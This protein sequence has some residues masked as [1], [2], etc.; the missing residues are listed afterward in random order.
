M[1]DAALR[2]TPL[3]DAHVSLGAKLVPFAG[4]EMPIQYPSG[5]VAE[6]RTVRGAVGLF[7]LSHM[8]EFHFRGDAALA[9][10]DRLVSS[11]IAGL[12]TGQ[13][14]YGLLCNEGGTIVDDVIVYRV[15]DDEVL[16]VVN[17]SNVVKDHAHLAS[18]PPR[19]PLA[20]ESLA[21]AL[22]AVRARAGI[23]AA[24]PRTALRHARGPP[25]GV[26]RAWLPATRSSPRAPGTPARRVR[27]FALAADAPLLW[28]APSPHARRRP[29]LVGLGARTPASS[30]PPPLRQR[31][32]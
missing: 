10:V 21:T 12:G 25:A 5:I 18:R 9:A 11:D 7:D 27:L 6:H 13:A 2:Q 22:V 19:Q 26:V 20:D 8:G 4:W 1:T 17:A 30:A 16:M 3:H 32:R 28:R 15:A 23:V 29:V 14:R 31:H 24:S